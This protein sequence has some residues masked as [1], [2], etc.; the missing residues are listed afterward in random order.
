MASAITNLGLTQFSSINVARNIKAQEL[1][2]S[3]NS[4]VASPS[5]GT[6]TLV[7]GSD[8]DFYEYGVLSFATTGAFVATTNLTYTRIGRMVFL[9]FPTINV[10]ATANAAINVAAGTLPVYLRPLFALVIPIT[11]NVNGAAANGRLNINADGS[12]AFFSTIGAGAFTSTQPSGVF[13]N[14]ATYM[15]G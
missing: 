8:L 15:I 7:A 14:C 11:A 4:Q 2:F 13:G 3:G 1:I 10:V 9:Q 12:F 6:A 5:L